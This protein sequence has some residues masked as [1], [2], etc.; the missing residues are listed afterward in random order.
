[1]ST[2][3]V[4]LTLYKDFNQSKPWGEF[5]VE[6]KGDKARVHGSVFVIPMVS[7][8][9][10]LSKHGQTGANCHYA[11]TVNGNR[12]YFISMYDINK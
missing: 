8:Y 10:K 7:R 9:C 5:Q 3:T 4:T 2:K 6:F 12:V 1:M 11:L